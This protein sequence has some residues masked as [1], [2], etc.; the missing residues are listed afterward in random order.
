M[1]TYSRCKKSEKWYRPQA[2][3]VLL[4]F[5]HRWWPWLLCLCTQSLYHFHKGCSCCGTRQKFDLELHDLSLQI[6]KLI[7][8]HVSAMCAVTLPS[9]SYYCPLSQYFQ[10][11]PCTIC[12]KW[13]VCNPVTFLCYGISPTLLPLLVPTASP[14][15][16][17][18]EG[19]LTE[20]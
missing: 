18:G 7:L 17:L 12:C 1:L 19:S 4:F 5:C 3:L 15:E 13:C 6:L 14:K 11:V 8:V 9:V 20:I 10:N 2:V 16:A